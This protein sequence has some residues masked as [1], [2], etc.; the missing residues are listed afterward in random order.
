MKRLGISVEGPTEREFVNRV[1]RPHLARHRIAVTAIDHLKGN[2]SLDRIRDALP[3]LLG[4]FDH[5]STFYD[6]YGFKRRNQRGIDELE[7]AIAGLVGVEQRRRLTPYIQKYEFEALL[8]AVPEQ[9]VEWLQGSAAQLADM[10]DAVS[11]CGSPEEVNDSV[12]TS[13]SHRLK[14]L[15]SGYDKKLHGPEIIELAGLAAIRR[16]CPRFDAW[17]SRLEG[18]A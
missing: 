10:Q 4:S 13:P 16:A 9:T 2:V 8:F 11:G 12:E 5:V 14:K 6:F 7:T 18:L 3:P 1:L 17:V 15:F